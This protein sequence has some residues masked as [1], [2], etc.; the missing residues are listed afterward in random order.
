MDDQ[1]GGLDPNAEALQ[2]SGPLRPVRPGDPADQQHRKKRPGPRTPSGKARVRLNA[3]RSGIHATDPVIPGIERIEDWEAHRA[4]V[5]ESLAPGGYL[6]AKLAERVAFGLWRLNR[7]IA[8]EQAEFTHVN[9]GREEFRLPL[10][11]ELDK[12]MRYEAHLS[13]QLYQAKHELEALQQQRRGEA[14]PLARLDVNVQGLPEA[15]RLPERGVKKQKLQNKSR[16]SDK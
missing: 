11:N 8:Y 16:N 14:T 12:I 15:S 9:K 6:E 2:P 1:A 13:R 7:V 4:G 3:V 10:S 5:L